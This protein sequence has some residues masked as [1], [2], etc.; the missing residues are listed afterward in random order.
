VFWKSKAMKT[1]QGSGNV[2]SDLG[3]ENADIL[4]LKA[5]LAAKI[6]RLLDANNLNPDDAQRLTGVSETDLGAIRNADL[7][8]IDIE[9]M[10]D[11]ITS[12]SLWHPPFDLKDWRNLW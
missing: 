9:K 4:Q 7:T 11:I 5:I 8:S 12:L 3:C 1:V 2:F 6:I 10:R